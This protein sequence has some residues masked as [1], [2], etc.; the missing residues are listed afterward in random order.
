MDEMIHTHRLSLASVKGF[1]AEVHVVNIP[2]WCGHQIRRYTSTAH[3]NQPWLLAW[4][5]AASNSPVGGRLLR[6]LHL[7]TA[8]ECRMKADVSTYYFHGGRARD[9]N[10]VSPCRVA[11]GSYASYR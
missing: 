7:F 10:S 8:K 2:P 11:Q 3:S 1:L 4:L 9:D 5:A 6:C